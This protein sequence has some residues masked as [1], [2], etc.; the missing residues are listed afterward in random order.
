MHTYHGRNLRLTEQTAKHSNY[1]VK[2]MS[3]PFYVLSKM[4]D[5]EVQEANRAT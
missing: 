1:T 2:E 3:T 5:S 4:R